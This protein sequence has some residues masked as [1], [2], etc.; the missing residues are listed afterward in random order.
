MNF[1]R[2]AALVLACAL[3]LSSCG[4]QLRG[5]ATLPFDTLYVPH[6]NGGMALKG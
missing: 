4:F 6:A 5:T 3:L 2:P 1:A